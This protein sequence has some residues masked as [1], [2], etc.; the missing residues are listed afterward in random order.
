MKKRRIMMV[1]TF[2]LPLMA[3][4]QS[5]L[6]E[7]Y[8]DMKNASSVYISKAMME[9][10]EEIFTKE[11]YIGKVSGQLEGIYFISSQHKEMKEK[12]KEDVLQFLKSGNYEDLIVH[13]GTGSQ[14]AFYIKR[15]QE[16]VKE[17]IMTTESDKKI[18]F[19]QLIGDLTLS[20]IKN[21]TTYNNYAK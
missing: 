8:S 12:I 11:Y 21:I 1:V 17:L 10:S 18:N 6:Y 7:K 3:M 15:T 4:A 14:T 2:I 13:K 9:L 19:I 5:R 16:N 20:D